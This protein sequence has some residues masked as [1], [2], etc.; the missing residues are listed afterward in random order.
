MLENKNI[1]WLGGSSCAGKSTL[2]Q[3]VAEQFHL[4]LY[5]CDEHFNGH[6]KEIDKTK[7]PAMYKV[8]SMT[9]NEAFFN[10]SVDE[11][12]RVYGQSF[13][14]DFLFVINDL[15][16]L[17]DKE[18][19]VEGNQLLPSLV[20]PYLKENHKAIWVVPTEYFQRK[21]YRKRSWM[22]EII[23]ETDEPETAFE[24]WMTR[25]ALFAKHIV[26][27]AKQLKLNLLEVNG[28]KDIRENFNLVCKYLRIEGR[29]RY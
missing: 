20:L 13:K 5:S 18:I 23:R 12:L 29:M 22:N 2:A 25:D 10:R 28:E 6:L 21:Q 24:N 8:S 3:M 14:E 26:K 17:E 27:E 4:K 15:A 16:R 1:Y 11:Q 9:A 7:Q 19:V